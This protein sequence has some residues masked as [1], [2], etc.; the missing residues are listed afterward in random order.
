M[1]YLG[2]IIALSVP[3]LSSCDR[4]KQ[5]QEKKEQSE[6]AMR[7]FEKTTN[8]MHD[9]MVKDFEA[10]GEIK[11]DPEAMDRA[12]Q[13]LRKAEQNL[14]GD[15]AAMA[16]VSAGL[17]ES[18]NREG[19]MIESKSAQLMT[20]PDF[21]GVTKVEHLAAKKLIVEDYM[22]MNSKLTAR[23]KDGLRSEIQAA[24]DKENISKTNQAAFIKE[25]NQSLAKRVP[26]ILIVRETDQ[27]ICELFLKQLDIL[28]KGFGNW[29]VDN[30]QLVFANEGDLTSYNALQEKIALEAAKQAEAQK[31][32]I[33]SK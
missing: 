17:M 32:I 10:T 24:L 21:S 3:F 11:H 7:D 6:Q 1:K 2:L 22:E 16:R 31:A 30:G 28:E 4:I 26:N 29:T 8:E 25:V 27:N 33:M 15:E 9:Q 5:N 14:S 13:N 20:V 23:Y 19:S 18:F 12:I